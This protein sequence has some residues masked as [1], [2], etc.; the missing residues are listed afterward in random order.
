MKNKTFKGLGIILLLL[1]FIALILT[2]I[3]KKA[4][5]KKPPKMAGRIAIVIDDWGYS[6]NNLLIIEQI[7]QPLT[8]AILPGLKNSNPVMQ[9]LNNLGFEI[10]LH[11][12]ME[13]KEKW[14]PAPN[15]EN[16]MITLGLD[17][18]GIRNIFEKDLSSVAFARGV[19]N[20]MGSRI[21]EDKK[22]SALVMAEAKKRKL[23]FFDSFVTNKSVCSALAKKIKIRFA[24]RDVFLDN[25]D[26]FGYIKGQLIKLK[27]LARRQGTAIGI[28][29]DRKNTLLVL[30]EMLA[31]LEAE[32]YKFVFLSQVVQ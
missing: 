31:Q 25:Q 20:H 6:L 11:L 10:I 19:S 21:T 13:P 8:C 2:P 17:A 14:G 29:H 32:G 15:L 4:M 18:E 5:V 23:Y 9:K 7:K 27:N 26:D 1:V 12:P 3:H 28:G 22:A 30:K 24:K 16:N